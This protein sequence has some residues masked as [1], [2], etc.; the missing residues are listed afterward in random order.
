MSPEAR[1]ERELEHL[2]RDC[3]SAIQYLYVWLAFNDY[4]SESKQAL[5]AI[6]R[7][8]LFW[9]ANMSALQA[10]LFITLG[11]IFDKNPKS[12]SIDRL[13]REAIKN[14]AIF[15]KASLA[16][17]K[18]RQ[19]PGAK[20]IRSHVSSA[21][22]P[23][24]ADFRRLRRFVQAKRKIYG[25]A[26]GRIRHKVFAHNASGSSQKT[27]ALFAKTKVGE[28]QRLLASLKAFYET[29]FQLYMNGQKPTIR[30]GGILSTKQMQR[31]P[32]SHRHNETLQERAF[33]ETYSF[34]NMY[35]G[36][37]KKLV[38]GRRP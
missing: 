29:M 37:T 5:A 16:R 8:P 27:D 6:N 18:H 19:S 2:R 24:S 30:Q 38:G 25:A 26:Y 3:N 35:T 32:A 1:F 36:G 10:S 34:L 7:T 20:W 17:R 9:L 31:R 4:L 15:S 22:I 21:Y 13:L 28:I 14:P 12:H 33:G 11:R 23:T